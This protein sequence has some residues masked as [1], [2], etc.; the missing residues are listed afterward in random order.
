M[1]EPFNEHSTSP[2][3]PFGGAPSLELPVLN[4]PPLHTSTHTTSIFTAP[5]AHRTLSQ[6]MTAPVGLA[7]VFTTTPSHVSMLTS[8]S[9]PS[10]T[11]PLSATAQPF[12]TNTNTQTTQSAV[13]TPQNSE[14][15]SLLP[16]MQEFLDMQR[17]Q[18]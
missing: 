4:F 7:P 17:Q 3:Q 9:R 13:S 8:T 12:Y 16:S 1:T 10:T 2:Q 11:T 15:G 5:L 18:L 14:A 6:G